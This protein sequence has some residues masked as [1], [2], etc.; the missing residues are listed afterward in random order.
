MLSN[1]KPDL[2]LVLKVKHFSISTFISHR[3][4]RQNVQNQHMLNMTSKCSGNI[5]L[6]FPTNSSDI[7]LFL[8]KVSSCG[9]SH[10]FACLVIGYVQLIQAVI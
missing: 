5:F 3:K 6:H 9:G 4:I 2:Y 1:Y 8:E 7:N 10:I